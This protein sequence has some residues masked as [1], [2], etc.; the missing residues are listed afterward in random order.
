[1]A[2]LR[3]NLNVTTYWFQTVWPKLNNGYEEEDV[4]ISDEGLFFKILFLIE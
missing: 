4:L 3:I 2:K 1:M